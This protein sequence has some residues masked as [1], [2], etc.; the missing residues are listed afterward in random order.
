MWGR[1]DILHDG[2]SAKPNEAGFAVYI[3]SVAVDT[4][5]SASW[6][7]DCVGVD[8]SDWVVILKYKTHLDSLPW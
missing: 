6:A 8:Q 2:D 4:W 1:F 7:D 5:R 3:G